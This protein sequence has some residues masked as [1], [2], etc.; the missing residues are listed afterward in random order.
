MDSLAYIYIYIHG[1]T[2]TLFSCCFRLAFRSELNENVLN[3]EVNR[4]LNIDSDKL[5]PCLGFEEGQCLGSEEGQCLDFEE[6]QCLG[7]EEGQC[8]V[9]EEGLSWFLVLKKDNVLVLK[10]TMSWF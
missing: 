3:M 7:S 1:P 4:K 2:S 9:F 5:G 10:K 8:L 6:G